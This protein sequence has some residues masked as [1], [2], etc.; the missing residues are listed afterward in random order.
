MTRF[1]RIGITWGDGTMATVLLFDVNETLLDLHALDPHFERIFG[2]AGVRREWFAQFIHSA[3]IATITNQYRPF[4]QIAMG[5]LDNIAR[6]KN[7]VLTEDD[8][9]AI[10]GGMVQLPAHAEVPAALEQLRGAGFRLATLT[11]ST[12]A[13]VK[14]QLEFAGLT[15]Y[16]EQSLSADRVQQLKPAAE[17]YQYAVQQMGAPLSQ[18]WLVAAHAWDIV[19]A[20]AVG[21]STA[22][23]ARPQMYTDPV[24]ASPQLSGHDLTAVA[25]QLIAQLG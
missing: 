10:R 3:F 9:Q 6:R 2:A 14:A 15:D 25:A 13:V 4:G 1:Y 23:V 17:P 8:K 7:I 12:E 16:F 5:A 20:A 11:N 19:G 24:F 18:T 21:L 22:F